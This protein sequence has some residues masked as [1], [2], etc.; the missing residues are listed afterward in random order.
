MGGGL[1]RAAAGVSRRATGV[2]RRP[3][4]AG[5]VFRRQAALSGIHRDGLVLPTQAARRGPPL[6]VTTGSAAASSLAAARV[7]LR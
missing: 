3:P 6:S 7:R 2:L 4:P 1:V 5:C